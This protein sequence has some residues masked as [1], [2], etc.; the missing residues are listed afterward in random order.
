MDLIEQLYLAFCIVPI[1]IAVTLVV[2]VAWMKQ[3]RFG[4][5][6]IRLVIVGIILLPIGTGMTI[7]GVHHYQQS[8]DVID[9][10]TIQF[11]NINNY[12]VV[13]CDLSYG[14]KVEIS[15][16]STTPLDISLSHPDYFDD[17]WSVT[18]IKGALSGNFSYE[19]EEINRYTVTFHNSDNKEGS[20]DIQVV[21]E[22]SATRYR[23]SLWLAVSGA[24][25]AGSVA[26]FI[27]VAHIGK[28]NDP[29]PP[30]FGF[31]DPFTPPSAEVPF[32]RSLEPYDGLKK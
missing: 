5:R 23:T 9:E 29:L 3:R 20:A 1:A 17:G 6:A 18:L 12:H 11:D 7:Y 22:R 31:Q 2:V 26:I 21:F 15:F 14:D 8:S 30:S 10:R 32:A 19:I 27:R 24:M 16:R 28:S 4:G 13:K 25:V